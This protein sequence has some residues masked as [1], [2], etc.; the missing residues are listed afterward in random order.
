M[1]ND[2]L[3]VGRSLGGLSYACGLFGPLQCRGSCYDLGG[4]QEVTKDLIERLNLHTHY[5]ILS[6]SPFSFLWVCFCPDNFS[7]SYR[8]DALTSNSPKY[9]LVMR[10]HSECRGVIEFI[11]QHWDGDF[12]FVYMIS[13]SLLVYGCAT[14]VDFLQILAIVL[15]SSSQLVLNKRQLSGSGEHVCPF[16]YSLFQLLTLCPCHH[17]LSLSAGCY[18]VVGSEFI[19]CVQ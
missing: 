15:R 16:P 18:K 14:T 2:S 5:C 11:L 19:P 4:L 17:L 1:Q 12:S 9:Q 10:R 3:L 8:T 6:V 7:C 13:S